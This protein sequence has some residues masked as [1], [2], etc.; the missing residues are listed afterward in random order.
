MNMSKLALRYPWSKWRKHTALWND[1]ELQPNLPETALLDESSLYVFLHKFPVV[2]AK[3]C[4]G[5]GGRGVIKLV[6]NGSC[7]SV[8]TTL[9]RYEVPLWLVYQKVKKLAGRQSYIVQQGINLVELNGSAIDFRA[10]L[11]KPAEDWSFMGIMGKVAVK[12]RIVTNHCRG[13]TSIT[14]TNAMQQSKCLT[15]EEIAE[16]EK[17][18]E[19]LS[20]HIAE[21]LRNKFPNV[22]ELGLDIGIDEE[23]RLWLIEANTRPQYNLFKDH[24]DGT[25]YRRIDRLIRTIRLPIRKNRRSV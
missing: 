6:R 7:V 19:S 21:A 24:E 23:L 4:Y 25:L 15:E 3:P 14:F 16:L 22:S 12:D 2:Y 8:R 18:V 17:K 13:G 9:N 20:T 5:G 10:L 1:P 11:L